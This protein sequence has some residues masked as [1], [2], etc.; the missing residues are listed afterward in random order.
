VALIAARGTDPAGPWP[1][2]RNDHPFYPSLVVPDHEGEIAFVAEEYADHN[3]GGHDTWTADID[4]D[5]YHGIGR[6]GAGQVVRFDDDGTRLFSTA[7]G[8]DEAHPDDLLVRDFSPTG[9]PARPTR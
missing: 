2:W 7:V 3:A 9:G 6:I 8:G 5:G 4:G 1:Y